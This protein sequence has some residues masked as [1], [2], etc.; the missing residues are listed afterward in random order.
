[1]NISKLVFEDVDSYIVTSEQTRNYF[2]GFHSTFGILIIIRDKS[3]Y[4]TDNRYAEVCNSFFE[5]TSV[6]PVII[7]KAGNGYVK[8]QEIIDSNNLKKMGFEDTMS[9]RDFTEL[10]ELVKVEL[11]PVGKYFEAVRSVKTSE[12]LEKIAKIMAISSEAFLKTLQLA[13]VGMTE[14]ELC[15]EINYQIYKMG[16]DSLA[17]ET[18]IASG[19]NGSKCHAVP[20]DR[21]IEKGD[22]V[23]MDFGGRLDGY[24][25]DIT[26]TIAFGKISQEQEKLYNTVLEAQELGLANIKPGMICGEVDGIVREFFKSKGLD[27]YFVHSLGHGVGVEVHEEPRLS[28]NC[29]IKL[30]ENMV[31]TI[32]PGLY[33]PGAMGVRIEDTVAVTKDGYRNFS[34]CSKELH[35]IKA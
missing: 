29:D 17:F 26:R 31:V 5:G 19:A 28:P 21:V 15:A 23:T 7:A 4:I 27:Q 20:S 30:V 1:M 13:R 14:K 18:I 35:I 25:A 12:E 24:C 22:L 11:V 6:E 32:E 9:V 2:T 34:T 10:K 33:M 3:F 8:A 16:A